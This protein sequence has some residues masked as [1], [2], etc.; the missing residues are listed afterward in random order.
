MASCKV[1][2]NL[3]VILSYADFTDILDRLHAGVF[4]NEKTKFWFDEIINANVFELYARGLSIAWK[5][6]Q[7]RWNWTS[8]EDTDGVQVAEAVNMPLLGV[9]KNFPMYMFTPR[10]SY[11]VSFILRKKE[12]NS[13]LDQL[14]KLKLPATQPRAN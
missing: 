10:T 1:P 5:D 8:M 13:G 2:D 12:D 3:D 11:E 4:L 9:K 14:V 7:H 6:D